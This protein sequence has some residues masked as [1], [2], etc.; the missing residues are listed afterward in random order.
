MPE[1]IALGYRRVLECFARNRFRGAGSATLHGQRREF[2]N[3]P[4]DAGPI[5]IN[6][7]R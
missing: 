3:G 2:K 1:A 6:G 5:T 7:E 4:D